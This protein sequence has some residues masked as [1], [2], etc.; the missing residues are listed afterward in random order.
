VETSLPRLLHPSNGIL[1][2]P[3]EMPASVSR[4][5]N[6]LALA[7][8]DAALG[9]MTR[10]DLVLHFRMD[11]DDAIQAFRGIPHPKVRR[12]AREFFGTGLEWPGDH[13]H[14]RFYDKL[15]EMEQ[16]RGD[17]MRLEF[18]LRGRKQLPA[19]WDGSAFDMVTAHLFY[20]R[21]ALGFEPRSLSRPS[22]LVGFLAWLE[23]N[24]GTVKGQRPLDVYLAMKKP[25][26]GRQ[27]RASVRRA[28]VPELVLDF[29]ELLEPDSLPDF[30]D[31]YPT[32]KPVLQVA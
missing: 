2:K 18:Q 8:P 12:A 5:R 10:A 7:A 27:L 28:S 24:A 14:I 32:P 20:R 11:P 16:R 3:S 30:I 9:Q 4:L 31:C 13:V 21:L 26:Y 15:R 23:R 29:R 6:L 1:L 22:D 25:E 17:I 19:I